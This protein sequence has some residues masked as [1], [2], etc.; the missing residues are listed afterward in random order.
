MNGL[1]VKNSKIEGKGLFA[2]KEFNEGD[3]I[4]IA[5]IN[6]NPTGMIGKFHNHSDNPN[7]HSISI[8][9]KKYLAALRPLMKGEE[10][11][12]DYRRQP[13]LEQPEDFK[14]FQDGGV[15][16][17]EEID[18]A[19]NAMMKARLAYAYMHGNP[20]AQ[21]M[22]VAPDQPYDFGDGITGTHYMASMDNYAVPQIQDING[23]LMLG[24]YGPESPEAIRFDTDEDAN[25]FAENY[26]DIT[27]DAS[28]RQ[29]EYA[30]GGEPKKRKKDSKGR[31]RSED[32]N[33]RTPLTPEM[34]EIMTPDEWGQY[35]QEVPEVYTTRTKEQQDIRNA[36][37]YQQRMAE[38]YPGRPTQSDAI[39][40][41][42]W[43]WQL[44]MLGA[45]G[46]LGRS[47]VKAAETAGSRALPYITGALETS[48]PGMAS[49]PGATVGNALGA[50]FA[51]DAIVNRLYPSA[52]KIQEGKYGEAATDIATGLLDLYGANM[53]SPAYKGVKATA[54]EL[55]KFL[56]TKELP[57][58]P[59]SFKSQIDWAKWNPDTP[60]YPELINEYNAIE[61]TTKAN[62]TWMKNP[63]GS[64]FKGSPEQFIQQ[65]SSW[66]KKAFG[67]S[68][69]INPDGSPT[70][71]YHGS[72]KKFDTFDESK[73]QLGDAGYSG[74]GIYTSP[75]K[76]TG[77]G[78]AVS[79]AKFHKGEIEPTVYELYGQANNPISSSQLINENKGRDLFNFYRDENWQGKLSPYESLR[80]YDAA[81]SDQLTGVQNIRPWHN[82][83]E[84]VFPTNKQLKSAIGNVGFFDMTNPNIYKI[85]IPGIIGASIQGLDRQQNGGE[86]KRK[87]YRFIKDT[88]E[89][90]EFPADEWGQYI[91]EEPEVVV[92]PLT[93]EQQQERNSQRNME[94]F[95]NIRAGMA[96]NNPHLYLP[97]GTLR[98]QA[99]QAAD[100]V[101]QLGA[102]GPAGLEGLGA[103]A[104]K[105]IPRTG[106]SL[107]T[108][109]NTG[110]GIH[111][112]TQVDQRIEDWKD[113]ATGEKDWKEA[114]AESLMT[115][116]ELYGGYDA[117]KTLLP[118]TYK[119]NPWAFKPDPE[120]Y[121]HRSP[122]LEN[123]INEETGMLQG[124][125][126]S[127]AG[128]LFNETAGPGLGK[129]INLKKGANNKLYFSK[130]V[131]LDFGRYNPETFNAAGKRIMSGQGYPGPYMV[132]VKGVPMGSSTKGRAPGLEPTRLES[133][134]VSK[135]P[136]SLD[137]VKFYKE[138]WA[139]GYKEIPKQLP[140]SPNA[141]N[142]LI[143]PEEI[144][145]G[146]LATL[147]NILNESLRIPKELKNQLVNR[148]DIKKAVPIFEDELTKLTSP[149]GIKRL[150]DLGVDD[151][152]D[153][154]KYLDKAKVY[155]RNNMK[156]GIGLYGK[157]AS[158][159]NLNFDELKKLPSD[160][161]KANDYRSVQSHE[162]GHMI[163]DYLKLKGKTK[164]ATTLDEQAVKELAPFVDPTNSS[165]KKINYFFKN[166]QE[167]LAHLRE[168]KQNMLNT[169]VIDDI[170]QTI[171]P[172]DLG[173]FYINNKGYEDRIMSFIKPGKKAYS[174][175]AK[176]LNKTP[177]IIPIALGSTALKEE[178]NGGFIGS[179]KMTKLKKFIK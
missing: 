122:N 70:I 158:Y 104:A 141:F 95:Q 28:Y 75:S 137:E 29:E 163:Q 106:I 54:S 119:I 39:Q 64:P 19:N 17:Q 59:N 2:D 107:G 88:A 165:N 10:I 7:A 56:G 31:Y 94:F 93:P 34:K 55:G 175:L 113:V 102:M 120:A 53:L 97:D 15:T 48:I 146:K 5:H 1:K 125:G 26:K 87:K 74:R 46:G 82:A 134:A 139:K 67:D 62:G 35:V 153:F 60:K 101:W 152:N 157:D 90:K 4:G 30:K 176:L 132:E 128:K 156:T 161:L 143:Q 40:P 83:R 167:P 130:G 110:F 140:G 100:W 154:V 9:N 136:I 47:A 131:P 160:L 117:A 33:I 169:G 164:N 177:A 49:I 85:A 138:H 32:G 27:P 114:A 112:A 109:A 81:I 23:Q 44:G 68:K 41:A 142:G 170:H 16:S 65:N 11:T 50:G 168:L 22:V 115:A 77:E 20:A 80:E 129:G 24:D 43:F 98:P 111:G 69:L 91:Q 73:F 178:K 72:P 172:D 166:Q 89:A 18:A 108:L 96:R 25:Y 151:I 162:I 123:I 173:N 57:G 149:E 66:F 42:D 3:L 58:S 105:Q 124:F 14:K 126:Q 71:Q 78:Y 127:E 135:R 171:T 147:K 76:T 45:A 155:T 150:K 121:Y 21:R 52:G 84:V 148:Q 116:L 92:R 13:D 36:L 8:G 51:G 99:A 118:Q 159:V 63:D 103:L 6:G 61:Q 144:N 12:V 38:L 133:Y 86:P 37:D 179:S 79:A 174:T 145:S